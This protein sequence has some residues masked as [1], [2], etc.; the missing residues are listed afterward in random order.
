MPL[1]FALALLLLSAPAFAEDPD[2]SAAEPDVEAV[3]DAS[4]DARPSDAQGSGGS[5]EPDVEAVTTDNSGETSGERPR[6]DG[7]DDRAEASG[8]GGGGGIPDMAPPVCPDQGVCAQGTRLN[9]ETGS[10]ERLC[11]EGLVFDQNCGAC[12]RC[13]LQEEPPCDPPHHGGAGVGSRML[14]AAVRSPGA[15]RRCRC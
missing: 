3:T 2:A 11:G 5:A 13:R 9:S 8:T 14:A 4:A 10:C 6:A 7:E 12:G 1:R 15:G